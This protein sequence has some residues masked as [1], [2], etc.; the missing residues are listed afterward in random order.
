M[1][2]KKSGSAKQQAEL[3]KRLQ[4]KRQRPAERKNQ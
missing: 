4:V 3:K 1:A 2:A